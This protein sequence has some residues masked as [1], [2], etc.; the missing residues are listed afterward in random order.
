[1]ADIGSKEDDACVPASG[2]WLA[3][4][5][6][7]DEVVDGDSVELGWEDTVEQLDGVRVVSTVWLSVL[8]VILQQH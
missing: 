2:L 7:V 4:C 8:V 6:A 1:M 5:V 3:S